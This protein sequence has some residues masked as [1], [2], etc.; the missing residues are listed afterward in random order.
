MTDIKSF[1][2]KTTVIV[3]L[4]I[5]SLFFVSNT[6][7]QQ[8]G[9]TLVLTDEQE[10]YSVAEYA[11][12]FVDEEVELTFEQISADDFKGEFKPAS[13]VDTS[14][15]ESAYWIRLEINNQALPTT[16]WLLIYNL[17]NINQ[18]SAYLPDLQGK[19]F[20][21]I[22]TGNTF[23]FSSREYEYHYYVFELKTPSGEKDTL[24][25]RLENVGGVT[26]S[27]LETVS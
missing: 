24:Y 2:K 5:I 4:I 11:E 23:P 7:A 13:E 15:G 20:R 12:I 9:L 8:S 10:I 19:N 26:L 22:H 25:L 16:S 14:S 17:Y 3:L 21:E 1:K 27:P 6:Q 18:I